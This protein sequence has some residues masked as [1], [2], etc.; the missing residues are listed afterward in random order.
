M[1]TKTRNPLKKLF[2]TVPAAD[3]F[4][5]DAGVGPD[6]T[7][8]ALAK[9]AHYFRTIANLAQSLYEMRLSSESW[10]AEQ[11]AAYGDGAAPVDVQISALRDPHMIGLLFT[12]ANVGDHAS[13]G[14]VEIERVRQRRRESEGEGITVTRPMP[15]RALADEYDA[16][17]PSDPGVD[18]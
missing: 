16:V 14:L 4:V 18:R 15:K 13:K 6:V 2:A 3:P 1:N 17:D 11:V 10:R 7:D 8:E 9:A 12:L 5:L